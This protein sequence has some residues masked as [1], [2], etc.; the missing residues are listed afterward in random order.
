MV[1]TYLR[2]RTFPL[3]SLWGIV[4]DFNQGNGMVGF[5]LG[6]RSLAVVSSAD[7]KSGRLVAEGQVGGW[8][9][10]NMVRTEFVVL[11]V[12]GKGRFH[13]NLVWCGVE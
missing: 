2:V 7:S 1:G 6:R 9:Q 5:T 8:I 11:G 13:R 4:E 10:N 12:E 3:F